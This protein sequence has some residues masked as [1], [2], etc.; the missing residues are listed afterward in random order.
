M[1]NSLI[2]R[3][4]SCD[5][6]CLPA[7][8]LIP[9][10]SEFVSF[11]D[12]DVLQEDRVTEVPESRI[13]RALFSSSAQDLIFPELGVSKN[14]SIF[15]DVREPVVQFG[16]QPGDIDVLIADG[17]RADLAIALQCKRVKV[18]ALNHDEDKANKIDSIAG[19]VRQAN[20][21]RSTFGFYR[22]YLVIIIQTVGK[23]RTRN[24]TLARG[25]S[26]DTLKKVYHFP[27]RESLHEDIGIVF[28]E[29]TQP[30]G[31]SWT[32]MAQIAIC[33]DQDAHRLEQPARL[34]N[35][36]QELMHKTNG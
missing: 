32:R 12:Y 34:T 36:I 4:K 15:Y 25:P 18:L 3:F 10:G 19:G 11:T 22:N 14:S 27:Q 2:F 24:N 1:S 6:I 9:A 16:Q 33:V 23:L 31:K 20:L 26:R 35:R 28:I 17:G 21:Q 7:N 30:T 8:T 5:D 13:I 29:I